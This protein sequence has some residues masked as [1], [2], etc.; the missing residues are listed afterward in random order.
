MAVIPPPLHVIDV[1]VLNR[2]ARINI[3]V[4]GGRVY[5]F[6]VISVDRCKVSGASPYGESGGQDDGASDRTS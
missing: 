2:I 5:V 6:G 4:D 1:S 3:D